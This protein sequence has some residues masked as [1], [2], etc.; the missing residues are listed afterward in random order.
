M[1]SVALCAVLVAFATA[2]ALAQD[3]PVNMEDAP[4]IQVA[5]YAV[6]SAN[7]D[8]LGPYGPTNSFSGDKIAVTLYQP[9]GDAYFY[10]QLTTALSP[11]VTSSVGIDIDH[12]YI[13][14]TPHTLPNWSF[15]F[16]RLPAPDGVEQDDEPL[17][18]VPIP[19]FLFDYARPSSLTGV[20]V[21]Y[22]PVGNFQLVGAVA[23]GWD[24]E[25][26]INNGKT[27]ALRAEWLPFDGMTVGLTGIY[28]PQFDSTT[29]FQR[30]L[31]VADVTY[32]KGPWIFALE[33]D[34]GHRRTGLRRPTGGLA[35]SSRRCGASPITGAW[36]PATRT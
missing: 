36:R 15:E 13:I 16:G 30:A 27:V 9:V 7:Y 3:V 6:G 12:L 25:Q 31:A 18:F 28:G 35:E 11:G 8:R 29:A 19:S 26:A 4:Q 32:E 2:A 22:T 24:V 14:Y 23:D 34:D 21:R 33:L 17:N 5:G 1:R 20:I 10:G